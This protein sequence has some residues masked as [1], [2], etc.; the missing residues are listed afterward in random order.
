MAYTTPLRNVPSV[1]NPLGKITKPDAAPT[2]EYVTFFSQLKAWLDGAN[3]AL[4]QVTP[5]EA[6]SFVAVG[7]LPAAA[8]N[9]GVRF[10]V[11]NATATTFWT[12]VAAGGANVVPVTS[13]GAV[14][15]IG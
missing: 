6:M 7:S 14:W 4:V 2:P 13:D 11:T 15:R 1:P 12:I 9:P 8:A 5:P 10:M 3:A